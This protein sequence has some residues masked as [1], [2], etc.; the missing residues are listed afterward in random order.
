MKTHY[1]IA[2]AMALLLS[3]CGGSS[4][5][6]GNPTPSGNNTSSNN[7]SSNNASGGGNADPNSSTNEGKKT[8]DT[9][10]LGNN[11]DWID[12]KTFVSGT[13]YTIKLTK[14]KIGQLP[15]TY[16]VAEQSK[17]VCSINGYTLTMPKFTSADKNQRQKCKFVVSSAGNN[18]YLSFESPERFVNVLPV[19]ASGEAH[20]EQGICASTAAKITRINPDEYMTVGKLSALGLNTNAIELI[21]TKIR[22]K[23]LPFS[24][25][26]NPQ[27]A[28]NNSLQILWLKQLFPGNEV[29]KAVLACKPKAAGNIEFNISYTQN[30]QTFNFRINAMAKAAGPAYSSIM[31][32]SKTGVTQC[33]EKFNA[34]VSCDPTD[35]THKGQD[36]EV[37]A[38]T[39]VSYQLHTAAN[40]DQCVK[41]VTNGKFWEQKTNDDGLHDVDWQYSYYQ[42]NGAY[43]QGDSGNNKGYV[44]AQAPSPAHCQ[45]VSPCTT[46]AY[47]K[48]LNTSSYCGKSTWRLPTVF[49][50]LNMANLGSPEVNGKVK[51]LP[52][53]FTHNKINPTRKT[54]TTPFGTSK[55]YTQA[56]TKGVTNYITGDAFK[57]FY[58]AD[59]VVNYLTLFPFDKLKQKQR[60][61]YV[62]SIRAIAD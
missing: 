13:V 23:S 29:Y 52:T 56:G 39:E 47:I 21:G 7:T 45:G 22:Y 44:G 46:Q 42:P 30:Q 50:M 34:D 24:I 10:V 55:V 9:W 17:D 37:Q 15:M 12:N 32:V 18:R 51:I 20:T 36:G 11:P 1:I 43:N 61:S 4:S 19:C 49:E 54:V 57:F 31:Q 33:A 5:T 53:P 40:G 41:D 28:C 59:G 60:E 14:S 16:T 2:F 58:R 6:D 8:W 26:T 25:T 48:Q 27:G 38:G 35:A 62:F 3:A